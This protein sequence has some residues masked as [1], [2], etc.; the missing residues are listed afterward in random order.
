MIRVFILDL[1]LK[2]K[3]ITL[4]SGDGVNTVINPHYK[5]KYVCLNVDNDIDAQNILDQEAKEL[6]EEQIK[7][8]FGDY[9]NMAS[10]AN[11]V[12]SEDGESVTFNY[13]P[14][15]EAEVVTKLKTT[16]LQELSTKA[17]IFEE[18][19]CK[20]MVIKSSIGYPMDGDRRSQ[21]NIQ[22]LI[23]VMTAQGLETTPYRCA[24]DVT[25]NLTKEQLQTVYLECLANGN[26]LYAQKWALEAAINAAGTKEELDAI[27]IKFTMMDFTKNEN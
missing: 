6:S 7:T 12:V 18:N 4:E 22:G 2:N 27:E 23:T 5:P 26:D 8:I 24:D 1:N 16:L 3:F 21:A 9:A 25:R 14:P 19:V 17:A 15:S 20:D 11:T 10:P 13:T